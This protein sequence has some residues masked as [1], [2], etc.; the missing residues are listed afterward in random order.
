MKCRKVLKVKIIQV[1]HLVS[2]KKTKL[3]FFGGEGGGILRKQTGF[4]QKLCRSLVVCQQVFWKIFEKNFGV[5][6]N[7]LFCSK[8]SSLNRVIPHEDKGLEV[9][10]VGRHSRLQVSKMIENFWYK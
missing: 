1:V 2:L 5:F 3:S 4:S 10:T 9:G 6:F 7:D 8:A